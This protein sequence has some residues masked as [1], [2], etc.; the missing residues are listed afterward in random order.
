MSKWGKVFPTVHPAAIFRDWSLRPVFFA[1]LEK[2]AHEATFPDVRRPARTIHVEPTYDDLLQFE[3]DYITP[4]RRLSVDI[5]TSGKYI[6]CIGFSPSTD[7]AL[8]VPFIR[9]DNS[10]YW[11]TAAEEHQVWMWVKHI[12]ETHP[13][14]IGQ[15]FLYDA[16]RLWRTYGIKTPGLRDDTMLLHHS[17]FIELEKGLG[18]LGSVYTNEARWKFMRTAET[19]KKEDE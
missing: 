10:P 12:C 7:R 15:N 5:E 16:H 14:I 18:F 2:A 6:T 19:M 3:R 13:H 8:V 17:L 9:A 11:S 4:S 1:D